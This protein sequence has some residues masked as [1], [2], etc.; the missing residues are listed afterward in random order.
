VTGPAWVVEYRFSSRL[1][2][3]FFS[4]LGRDREEIVRLWSH[5]PMKAVRFCRQEDAQTVSDGN[6]HRVLMKDFSR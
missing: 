5:D 1:N 4:G 3:R 6:Y 2:P